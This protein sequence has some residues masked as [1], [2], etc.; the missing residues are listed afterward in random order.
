MWT[1]RGPDGV[2]DAEP[3]E[4]VERVGC[5]LDAGA[6]FGEVAAAL[7]HQHPVTLPGDAHRGRQPAYAASCDEYL[8]HLVS[9]SLVVAD[10]SVVPAL[11]HAAG[12]G[13]E[14]GKGRAAGSRNACRDS[15]SFRKGRCRPERARVFAEFTGT[16]L[17]SPEFPRP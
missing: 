8:R 13:F 2:P 16:R 5:Q 14:S 6:E 11:L 10:R 17:N 12:G 4:G 7:Q 1:A 3:V 9:R 15:A